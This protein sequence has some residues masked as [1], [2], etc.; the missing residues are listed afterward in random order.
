MKELTYLLYILSNAISSLNPTLIDLLQNWLALNLNFNLTNIMPRDFCH[1]LS[2]NHKQTQRFIE[3]YNTNSSEQFFDLLTKYEI[4]SVNLF[5]P[6][7]PASLLQIPDPPLVLYY[8]GDI[9]FLSKAQCIALVGTRRKTNYGEQ[10]C[11]KLISGLVENNIT[12]VSGLA[13]G[14]D[15]TCHRLALQNNLKTIAVLGSGIDDETIYPKTN[16]R[17]AQEIINSGSALISEYPPLTPAQPYQFVARNRIIAGL[18]LATIII[19][20]A[21]KSGALITADFALEYNRSVFAVPGSIFSNLSAGPNWLL[22]QGA[23]AINKPED[24]LNFLG[25]ESKP[26]KQEIY[27]Q[28][29]K[30]ELCVLKCIQHEPVSFDCLVEETKLSVPELQIALGNLE[31]NKIISQISPQIFSKL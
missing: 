22:S 21:Q 3:V 18:S 24:I 13:Y 28:F 25:V 15:A 12:I 7:Y 9:S 19:E 2:L 26:I 8:R 17:L 14:I 27:T 20:C 23:G 1:D 11:T 30:Q 16:F 6:S 10:V 5:E 31:L 29:T 4:K